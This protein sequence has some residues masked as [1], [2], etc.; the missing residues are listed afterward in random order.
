M[1][2][3]FTFARHVLCF[4]AM[5]LQLSIRISRN[6][7]IY[8]LEVGDGNNDE[9]SWSPG[10]QELP[11]FIVDTRGLLSEV[12]LSGFRAAKRCALWMLPHL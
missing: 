5:A 12:E 1:S 8:I 2:L 11:Q 4:A 7:G 10:A 3:H 9:H 6:T